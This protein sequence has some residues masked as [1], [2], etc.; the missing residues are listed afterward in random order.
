MSWKVLIQV[1]KLQDP[2]FFNSVTIPLNNLSSHIQHT[3]EH[4]SLGE[5]GKR[6]RDTEWKTQDKTT[7][8]ITTKGNNAFSAEHLLS[9]PFHGQ[10]LTHF[11]RGI[12]AGLA[13]SS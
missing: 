2:D 7:V 13:E 9:S 4:T 11:T 12:K 3:P 10:E 1:F 8:Q 6:I 5:G